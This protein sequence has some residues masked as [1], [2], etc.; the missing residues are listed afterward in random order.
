MLRR[1]QDPTGTLKGRVRV[2]CN[3]GGR[4]PG[5]SR[6]TSPVRAPRSMVAWTL[7][8]ALLGLPGCLPF[9]APPSV[10]FV[11]VEL[12]TLGLRSGTAEVTLDVT[13]HGSRETTIRALLY[14]V[15]V[16]R[17]GEEGEWVTLAEGAH[18]KEVRLPGKGT[19]RVSV[20]VPFEYEAVGAAIMS[21]LAEGGCPYRISGEVSTGRSGVWVNI[22]FRDRGVL[23]P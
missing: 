16:K 14:T 21:F 20:P 6:A 4:D 23:K 11:G 2:F 15:E 22:P 18:N 17:P 1:G 7:G 13:N 3:P 8:L 12:K 5:M 10:D 9:L 19:Q